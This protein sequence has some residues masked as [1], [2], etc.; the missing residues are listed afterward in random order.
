MLPFSSRTSVML[1]PLCSSGLSEN[2]HDQICSYFGTLVVGLE[3]GKYNISTKSNEENLSM[4][5]YLPPILPGEF[6]TM[7]PSSCFYAVIM[8]LLPPWEKFGR[9]CIVV[10]WEEHS[11]LCQLYVQY[12]LFKSMLENMAEKNG[13]RDVW[14]FLQL[15]FPRIYKFYGGT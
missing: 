11:S 8:F 4:S 3:D 13:Y 6:S 1:K 10:L 2:E 9:T 14:M 5:F 12:Q 7:I 15:W